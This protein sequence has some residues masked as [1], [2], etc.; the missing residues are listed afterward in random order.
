MKI[1]QDFAH[2]DFMVDHIKDFKAFLMSF[3]IVLGRLNQHEAPTKLTCLTKN[4]FSTLYTEITEGK[5][6]VD[7]LN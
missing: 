5:S 6:R 1:Y 7:Q 2:T 4:L 3:K